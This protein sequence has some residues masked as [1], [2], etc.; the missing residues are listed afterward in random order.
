MWILIF[1]L[2]LIG[3]VLCLPRAA[4]AKEVAWS[5]CGENGPEHWAELSKEFAAAIGNAQS[6]V[7][8][9]SEMVRQ[10]QGRPISFHYSPGGYTVLDNGHTLLMVPDD[11]AAS[12]IVLGE[13]TYHLQQFHFHV[14]SE[15]TVNGVPYDM[16]IHFVHRNADGD[17]AVV[18]LLVCEGAENELIARSWAVAPETAGEDAVRVDGVYDP[19]HFLPANLDNIQYCGSLTTPP[20]V[21]G[22]TWVLLKEH[23]EASKDQLEHFLRVIGENARPVQ[24]GIRQ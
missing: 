23:G 16:E 15:H 22:V 17:L 5:Y 11:K 4:E 2:I 9:A 3:L 10:N 12:Y 6:P 19:A 21:E 24:R 13:E 8:I 14:P 1:I 20:T 18:G 7:D